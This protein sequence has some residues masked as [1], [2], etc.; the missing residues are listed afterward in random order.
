[1]SLFDYVTRHL[2]TG[3]RGSFAASLGDAWCRA[4]SGN[5][6]KLEAAF[7]HIFTVLKGLP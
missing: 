2:C 4:D 5:R 6:A 3:F 1:M 7:P